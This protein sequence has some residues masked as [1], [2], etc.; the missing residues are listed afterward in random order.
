MNDGCQ[1]KGRGRIGSWNTSRLTVPVE[2]FLDLSESVPSFFPKVVTP[3]IFVVKFTME[4][5]DNLLCCS[6]KVQ[7]EE[8]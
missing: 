8:V 3:I 7:Q 6:L 2:K 4:G 1:G 5:S